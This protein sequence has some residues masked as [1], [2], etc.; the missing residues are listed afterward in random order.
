MMVGSREET[1]SSAIEKPSD[2]PKVEDDFDIT[3][4]KIDVKDRQEFLCKV[5]LKNFLF[6]I[7]FKFRLVLLLSKCKHIALCESLSLCI[8]L[9]FGF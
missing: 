7:S 2:L 4:E 9:N 3:E 8:V 1:I 6:V 5:E